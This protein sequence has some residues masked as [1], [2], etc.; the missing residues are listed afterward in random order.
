MNI[1]TGATHIFSG[2]KIRISQPINTL[3]AIK[4]NTATKRVVL[5]NKMVL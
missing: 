3:V 5:Q 2:H 1:S 4:P